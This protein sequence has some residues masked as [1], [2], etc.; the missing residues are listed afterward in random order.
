[1]NE[2]V[3]GFPSGCRPPVKEDAIASH[4]AG[5]ADLAAGFGI[6]RRLVDEHRAGFAI[7]ELGP[8]AFSVANER[9]DGAFGGLGL[10]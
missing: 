2:G 9:G 6:E 4:R 1:M 8:L 10:T 5:V 3:P 7:V